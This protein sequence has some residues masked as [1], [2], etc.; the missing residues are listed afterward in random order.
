MKS[1]WLLNNYK[2][3]KMQM[4]NN[5]AQH[6]EKESKLTM[7]TRH[8]C[9]NDSRNLRLQVDLMNTNQAH[10][11]LNQVTENLLKNSIPQKVCRVGRGDAILFK[12]KETGN[13]EQP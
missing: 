9:G 11:R 12:D 5:I 8:T 7:R 2:P 4:I 6:I 10:K 1:T 3:R 13:N